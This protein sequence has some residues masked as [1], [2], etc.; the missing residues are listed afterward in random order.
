[1][2]QLRDLFDTCLDYSQKVVDDSQYDSAFFIACTHY[3]T[4]V[5]PI[6]R[7]TYAEVEAVKTLSST[8]DD[9]CLTLL[10][11]DVMGDSTIIRVVDDADNETY[12]CMTVPITYDDY[13]LPRAYFSTF[14]NIVKLILNEA[15]K[16]NFQLMEQVGVELTIDVQDLDM[17]QYFELLERKYN[18]EPIMCCIE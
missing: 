14:L 15:E 3:F 4:Y 6:K 9:T 5:S 1:M 7:Y 17:Q 12:I 18:I 16:D 11:N 13:L 2:K 8:T 10:Q